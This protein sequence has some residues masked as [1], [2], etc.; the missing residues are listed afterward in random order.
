M[1]IQ[2][3]TR[4][5][6]DAAPARDT[7]RDTPRAMQE[8]DGDASRGTIPRDVLMLSTTFPRDAD[9]PAGRFLL[10]LLAA[11]PPRVEL[12]MPDDPRARGSS[13]LPGL[14]RHLFR[15]RGLFHGDGALANLTAGRCTRTG[16]LVS[17]ASLLVATLRRA[18]GKRVVWTHW[19]VPSGV[20]GALCQRLR[21][22]AHVLSLHSGDLWWLETHRGGRAVARFLARNST[23]I[24][25]PTPLLAERFLRL[26]GRRPA[27]LGT[28]VADHLPA[29]GSHLR[30][31]PARVG[32]LCRLASGKG[33]EA[34][35][36]AWPADAPALELAGQGALASALETRARGRANI[37]L[38]GPLVGHAK[39]AWLAELGAFV[40]P[41]G[42]TPWGQAEGLPVAVLEAF[43]AGLPVL[44]Y[45]SS[46]PGGPLVHGGNAL[47]APDDRP[48]LLVAAARTLF[49]DAGLRARLAA[50]ARVAAEP[51]LLA[52]VAPRWNALLDDPAGALSC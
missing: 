40:A 21:G 18:A 37:R 9:D 19:A 10:D 29:D 43:S 35:V 20:A 4:S 15:Q 34:L 33:L 42:R 52:R 3:P 28:G 27:V 13:P 8:R 50:G 14:P 11:L 36:E 23:A 32:S 44:A 7:A 6:R 45:D 46:C 17:L 30:P 2:V 24:L 25:A 1:P 38:V 39:S 26:S 48:G 51:H 47:L 49:G 5:A 16:A 22:C 41:Y 31:R 12:L